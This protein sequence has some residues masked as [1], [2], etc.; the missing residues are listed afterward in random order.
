MELL[1]LPTELILRII[2]LFVGDIGAL[3]VADYRLVCKLFAHEIQEEILKRQPLTVYSTDEL[4]IPSPM[5]RH[6]FIAIDNARFE[7]LFAQHGGTII[8]HEVFRR[9]KAPLPIV[10]YLRN[11]VNALLEHEKS[12]FTDDL[13]KQYTMQVCTALSSVYYKQLRWRLFL[14]DYSEIREPDIADDL[15]AALAAT[16]KLQQLTDLVSGNPGRLRESCSCFPSPLEAAAACDQVHVVKAIIDILS[17]HDSKTEKTSRPGNWPGLI[18][19][20][21]KGAKGSG[22]I[23]LDDCLPSSQSHSFSWFRLTKEVARHADKGFMK[24]VF[25][26]HMYID[27]AR[28]GLEKHE[29]DYVLKEGSCSVLRAIIQDGYLDPNGTIG[30]LT[31]LTLAIQHHRYDLAQ[32]LIQHGA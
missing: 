29:V 6:I 32:V 11:L 26:S 25:K 31:P 16:G 4:K 30:D 27:R 22:N 5:G 1:D 23:L 7:K 10:E 3:Y 18:A 17:T 20:I 14:R 13:Q 19:A 12:Q 28:K 9:Q 2:G 15:P 8:S 21:R 24:R